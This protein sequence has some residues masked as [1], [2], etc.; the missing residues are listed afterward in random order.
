MYIL[1]DQII[2]HSNQEATRD[3]NSRFIKI[4]CKLNEHNSLVVKEAF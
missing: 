1:Q 3:T 4:I 2:F